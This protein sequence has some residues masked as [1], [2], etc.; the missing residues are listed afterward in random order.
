MDLIK[1]TKKNNKNGIISFYDNASV[2]S[3]NQ[4]DKLSLNKI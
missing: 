3:G 2:I 1:S 4:I